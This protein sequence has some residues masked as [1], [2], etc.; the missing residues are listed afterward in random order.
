MISIPFSGSKRN[1]YKTVREIVISGGYDTVFEPFGGSCV[2]SAN[3]FNDGIVERAVV[4]DYDKLFDT[5]EEFLDVKDW[6]VTECFKRGMT[7]HNRDSKGPYYID[8][9]NGKK[10]HTD[11]AVLNESERNILRE[12]ISKVDKKWWRLLS[13]GNNF[14]YSM[15]HMNKEIK[16]RHFLLFDRHLE[17][18]LQREFLKVI[19]QLERQSMD[20]RDFLNNYK[21]EITEKTLII[22]DPPYLETGQ[23]QY[24]GSFNEE[25]TIEL[26]EYVSELDCDFIFFNHNPDKV[27]HWLRGLDYEVSTINISQAQR[28]R[29]DVMAY[30]KRKR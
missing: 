22:L 5:Y 11:T 12:V 7:R 6:V 13:L 18:D 29:K 25:K 1:S 30:I 28:V 9:K 19:L 10:V 27:K 16:L 26:I 15:A 8:P 24:K 2:L 4:N 14:C 23:T 17:T 3:L 21:D 20:W